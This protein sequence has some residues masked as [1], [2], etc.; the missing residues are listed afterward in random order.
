[1]KSNICGILLLTMMPT[2]VFGDI[3][4]DRRKYVDWNTAPYNNYVRICIE[5]G[6]GTGQFIS[7]AHIL[8]TKSLARC[9]GV[10]G[11][12][13]CFIYTSDGGAYPATLVQAGGGTSKCEPDA[14]KGESDWAVLALQYRD[15]MLTRLNSKQFGFKPGTSANNGL[16]RGGFGDLR[17]L[18]DQDVKDIKTA[19][20][21]W[22]KYTYPDGLKSDEGT[23]HGANMEPEGYDIY[24]KKGAK[25]AT[26]LS[27]FK[28]L[29]GKDFISDYLGDNE[30]FKVIENCSLKQNTGNV[31]M[32]DCATWDG[33]NGAAILDNNNRVVALSTDP[34][35]SIGGIGDGNVAISVNDVFNS[36][37]EMLGVPLK[38]ERRPDPRDVNDTIY[39]HANGDISM[40][41]GGYM[42]WRN[43]NI[44]NI[45]Y[46]LKDSRVI[47]HGGRKARNSLRGRFAVFASEQEG[48]EALR[49]M[50]RGPVY[51]KMTI[52]DAMNKYAPKSDGNNPGKYAESIATAIGKKNKEA[53]I[54]LGSL[55]DNEMEE[56]IKVIRRKEGWKEGSIIDCN[57]NPARCK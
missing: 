4:M 14:I 39:Y 7:A 47:G 23:Q 40:R 24:E 10:S 31:F 8:T 28:E 1:M 11:R 43:N 17:V 56:V 54:K 20:T 26:F 37:K 53:T 48:K 55:S 6:C 49:T 30:R 22:I 9:C 16:W 15:N 32:H 27:K 52:L 45:N 29:T 18:T 44:G 35:N 3:G 46:G 5:S 50:L 21:E 42:A 41:T 34:K 12:A 2:I 57:A 19:Y 38:A 51:G 36:V 33:D 25:F 13:P